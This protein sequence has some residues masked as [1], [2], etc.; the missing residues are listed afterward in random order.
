MYVSPSIA[1]A[2]NTEDDYQVQISPLNRTVHFEGSLVTVTC[3]VSR[4]D[5]LHPPN[6]CRANGTQCTG[7]EEI[8]GV[9]QNLTSFVTSSCTWISQLEIPSFSADT[10]GDYRCFIPGTNHSDH[11]TLGLTLQGEMQ[12]RL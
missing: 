9:F 2:I 10:V 8:D 6:W 1:C 3:L 4:V 7:V 11:I 5:R 12:T